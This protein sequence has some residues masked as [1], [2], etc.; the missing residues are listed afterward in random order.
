MK[1]CFETFGCRLNRAEALQQEAEYLEK[2]WERTE[3]HSDADLFI[4]RGCS[5]T[6]RAQHEC[7]KLIA[8]LKKH[9][10]NIPIRICG[11]LE[12]KNLS[13]G[14]TRFPGN[15]QAAQTSQPL[16]SSTAQPLPTRTARAYL[17]CQDGCSG[18]C[19]F[20]IV[21][22]FRGSSVSIPFDDLVD[23][24]KRFI[25]AGYHEIVLTGCNLA[26]YASNGKCFPELVAALAELTPVR[27]LPPRPDERQSSFCRV[28]IG[29][30]EPGA[31]AIETVDVMAEHANVCRFLH[32]PV[33]SG[34]N[35]ILTAMRRPYLVRDVEELVNRAI[36]KMP[37]IGLG[38]DLMTG[39]P[40]ETDNDFLATKGFVKRLAFSNVHVFPYS[41]RPGTLAVGFPCPISRETR[42]QRAHELAD[43]ARVYRAK[44]AKKFIGKDVE[45][46]I[47]D[48][49]K[50][51]GW[52]GEYFT[53][54][55]TNK[56]RSAPKRKE[57]V[58]VHVMDAH[59]DRLKAIIVHYGNHAEEE[60][61]SHRPD[62][63]FAA[64][65]RDDTPKDPSNSSGT[66]PNC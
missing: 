13:P 66:P 4:V 29:S 7:E 64:R 39:F 34:S 14:Q 52:T 5:V 21:P 60:A 41:E 59:R 32:I 50:L 26:L 45:M 22:K 48:E 35:A 1:V 40:G 8:H 49:K 42:R 25:D 27:A 55:I 18:K 6:R 15:A 3:K 63:R 51:T 54:E 20:C 11:C 16:N 44:A 17:K 65:G 12:D 30:L 46:L 9:Y 57:L 62:A 38:C 33:Q 47:E 43:I 31:C 58:R 19:T 10:P 37:F 36:D 56:N 28:R 24:A 23:K 61:L 53:C 2:G